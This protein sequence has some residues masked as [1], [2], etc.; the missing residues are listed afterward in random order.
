MHIASFALIAGVHILTHEA[1]VHSSF[2]WQ[3][4]AEIAHHALV[5]NSSLLALVEVTI[6]FLL[7]DRNKVFHLFAHDSLY[8]E[9]GLL[10]DHAP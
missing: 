6:C 9:S 5:N 3:S 4:L 2:N 7:L 8:S 10:T 1:L